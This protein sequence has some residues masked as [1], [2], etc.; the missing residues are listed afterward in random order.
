MEENIE[1]PK[2][3]RNIKK[4]ALIIAG[5]ILLLAV[6]VFGA[7]RFFPIGSSTTD[8]QVAPSAQEI[9]NPLSLNAGL[10][11]SVSN[12]ELT[13]GEAVT[14][15]VDL[16]TVQESIV[17]GGTFVVTYDSSVISDITLTPITGDTGLFGTEAVVSSVQYNPG[18]IVFSIDLPENATPVRGEG[19]I[20]EL[21][22]TIV[23]ESKGPASTK[24]SFDMERSSTYLVLDGMK[25]ELRTVGSDLDITFINSPALAPDAQERLLQQQQLLQ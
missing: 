16:F 15:D 11:F 12:F 1:Q 13:P 25:Q 2:T 14:V 24:I 9:E 8:E 7:L 10:S 5:G 20:A 21:N 4:L 18:N 22:F 23:D 6:L 17:S 3:K 19:R